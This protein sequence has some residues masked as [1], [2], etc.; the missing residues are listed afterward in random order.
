MLEKS[1]LAR[2]LK[3]TNFNINLQEGVVFKYGNALMNSLPTFY[4]LSNDDPLDFLDE[5]HIRCSAQNI[6]GLTT[7]ILKM[8]CFPLTLKEKAEEWY[9]SLG[10]V[11]DEWIKLENRFL[12]KFYPLGKTNA[13]RREMQNFSQIDD[14]SFSEGG[15]FYHTCEDEIYALIEKIVEID[16]QHAGLRQN[17]RTM[18]QRQTRSLDE[19]TS[20]LNKVLNSD[21]PLIKAMICSFCHSRDHEN[22][23]CKEE[24]EVNIVRY[25]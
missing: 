22:G 4:G 12:Q 10:V 1:N 13:S 20:A 7:K 9:R 11:F 18:N 3:Q 8:K 6:L 24:E 5:F 2:S 15:S 17:G 19:L 21:S 14:E 23:A 16:M 25:N